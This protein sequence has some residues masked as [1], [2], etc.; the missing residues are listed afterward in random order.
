SSRRRHT[1]FSRDW[2]SDVCSSD[3][4]GGL[5]P[6]VAVDRSLHGEGARTVVAVLWVRVAVVLEARDDRDLAHVLGPVE[7]RGER[8]RVAGREI[9]RASCRGRVW[10]G[11]AAGAWQ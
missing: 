9:G 5:V 10:S 6:L 1:R 2:S 8:H 11:G 7:L 3:L 4:V